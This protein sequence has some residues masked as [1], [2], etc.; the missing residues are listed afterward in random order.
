MTD[1][2]S[3]LQALSDKARESAL[4]FLVGLWSFVKILAFYLVAM[5]LAVIAMPFALVWIGISEI[6]ALG[7]K[8]R[9]P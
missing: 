1:T 8:A 9:R 3:A 5:P 4:D 2:Q 6:T 7:R